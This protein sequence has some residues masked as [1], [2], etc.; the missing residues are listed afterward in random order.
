MVRVNQKLTKQFIMIN[1]IK[2]RYIFFLISALMLV[3]GIFSLLRFGLLP[4][5]DF[6]GG[7][8]VEVGIQGF[9]ENKFKEVL[10]VQ[11]INLESIQKTDK[12]TLSIQL[13]PISQKQLDEIKNSLDK[14]GSKI[15][16]K[17][18]TVVGPSAGHELLRQT[19][20]AVAI[21]VIAILSYVA[22]AFKDIKFGVCAV[23]AMLHD[24]FIL[25]GAYSIFGHFWGVRVD[26]LFVTAVLTT[27]TF[28]VHDTIV[29]FD[30]VRELQRRR[31]SWTV[32]EQANQAVSDTLVRSFNN[33]LTI[34]FMLLA[35]V[36]LGG[37]TTRWFTTALLIGAIVGTYSSPF[38]AVPLLVE[39][40][41][42]G[43]FLQRR[44]R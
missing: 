39:V 34:I 43:K 13:P 40:G 27:L 2:Y 1:W 9:D 16:I 41:R 18:F 5:V 25:L 29:V 37:S 7:S 21:A 28:S 38:N 10:Q 23:L 12:D 26:L 14:N 30:R 11:K 19:L 44:K 17:S 3:P 6:T 4:A 22:F 31:K 20:A 42:L 8:Q 36:L 35:L 33:S 32:E 24:G 15:D